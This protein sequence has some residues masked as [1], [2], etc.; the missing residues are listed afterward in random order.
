MDLNF[1]KASLNDIDTIVFFYKKAGWVSKNENNFNW[2]YELI[3]TSFCFSLVKID[4]K[5]VGMGRLVTD[6]KSDTYIQDLFVLNEYRSKG[7]GKKLVN[8]LVDYA[9]KNGI[10]WIALIAEPGTRAFYE[11]LGFK[12]MK[13][14]VPMKYSI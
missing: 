14:H 9:K 4:K 3:K 2:L 6:T 11:K 12:E 7:I 10:H 5:I 8:H 1:T 13:E